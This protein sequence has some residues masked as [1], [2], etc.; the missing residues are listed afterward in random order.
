[1]ISL[2]MLLLSLLLG[3]SLPQIALG[4][5]ASDDST[6]PDA[7]KAADGE[8][9]GQAEWWE[10]HPRPSDGWRLGLQS[11]V[12]THRN[13][14]AIPVGVVGGIGATAAIIGVGM[15]LSDPFNEPVPLV[16]GLG[17]LGVTALMAGAA[18]PTLGSISRALDRFDD[19]ARL[20]QFL[21][22]TRRTLGIISVVFGATG[23][24]AGLLTPFTFGLSAIPS[25]ALTATGVML[26][27]ASLTF[28]IFETK[29]GRFTTPH[30]SRGRFGQRA[31]PRRPA[32]PRLVSANPLSVRLVF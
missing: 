19:P 26:G 12:R 24:V 5:V 25:A 13:S 27:Q 4:Q 30:G 21:K 22:R 7:T 11:E 1:M 29:V 6:Q 10:L 9:A 31:L 8:Q 2:R 28:L 14:W 15:T 16:I 20:H 18:F 17:S 32:P 3:L 23:L